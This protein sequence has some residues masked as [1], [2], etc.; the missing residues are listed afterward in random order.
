MLLVKGCIRIEVVSIPVYFNAFHFFKNIFGTWSASVDFAVDHRG[1][2]AASAKQT[3]V[4]CDNVKTVF[5]GPRRIEP[6]PAWEN[7]NFVSPY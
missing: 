2:S 7:I 6:Y 4:V 5:K 3:I 1:L